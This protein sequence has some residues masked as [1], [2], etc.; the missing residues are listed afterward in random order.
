MVIWN[1]PIVSWPHVGYSKSPISV[2]TICVTPRNLAVSVNISIIEVNKYTYIFISSRGAV[3]WYQ[4]FLDSLPSLNLLLPIPISD[5]FWKAPE[6]LRNDGMIRGNKKGD[7]Y[8]FA[9]IL[10]EMI[11]RKGPYGGI[12]L[13]PKGNNNAKK[14]DYRLRIGICSETI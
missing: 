4:L 6:L 1:P 7:I 3:L 10:F 12:D 8:S 14:Y 13:E 2:F 9:I 5:L 11:G